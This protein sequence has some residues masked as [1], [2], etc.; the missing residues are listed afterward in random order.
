MVPTAKNIQFAANLRMLFGALDELVMRSVFVNSMTSAG[1]VDESG[2]F[3][4]ASFRR[5]FPVHIRPRSYT[6]VLQ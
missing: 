3:G 4:V 2:M 5:G 1:S 6:A